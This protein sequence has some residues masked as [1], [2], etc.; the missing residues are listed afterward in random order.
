MNV[1]LSETQAKALA[2]AWFGPGGTAEWID[3]E[4]EA[5]PCTVG[6]WTPEVPVDGK[7]Y[8]DNFPEFSCRGIGNTWAAAFKEADPRRWRG[9]HVCEQLRRRRT[10]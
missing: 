2:A 10:K 6:V 4:N 5:K 9:Y 7:D 1:V 3:D 8:G